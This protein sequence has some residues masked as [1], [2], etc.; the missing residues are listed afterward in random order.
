M[1]SGIDGGSG[2]VI[3]DLQSSFIPRCPGS[4]VIQRLILEVGD[5]IE[6]KCAV[7]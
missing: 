7:I 5:G 4:V 1:P 6:T 2:L 3:E